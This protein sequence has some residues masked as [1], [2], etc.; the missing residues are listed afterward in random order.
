[1]AESRLHKQL[2]RSI[3]S[4][5]ETIP[6]CCADFIEADLDNYNTRTTRVVGGYYPDVFYK[7]TNK[8]II[9]EAKTENDLINP[10]TLNQLLS[11]I[12]EVSLF[13]GERHIVLCVP[14]IAYFSLF[15][16]VNRLVEK[17]NVK[18]VTYH[19]LSDNSISEILC[20]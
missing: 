11:Y 18:N 19:L 3:V 12:E 2:V 10:H 16:Y 1:M 9:G 5:I 14:F 13:D 15:N 6:N 20:L 17:E 4:Y 7:D 8:I